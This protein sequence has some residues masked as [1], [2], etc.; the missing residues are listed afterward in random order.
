ME[1]GKR[2]GA[3]AQG[4][5]GF[6]GSEPGLQEMNDWQLCALLCAARLVH[7][8]DATEAEDQRSI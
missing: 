8:H 3:G 6:Q 7:Q 1:G 5:D 2:L 4:T